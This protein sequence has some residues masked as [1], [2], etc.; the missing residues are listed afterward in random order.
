MNND[1]DTNE[2]SISADEINLRSEQ[3]SITAQKQFSNGA[4]A[5]AVIFGIAPMMYGIFA[6]DYETAVGGA[7]AMVLFAIAGVCRKYKFR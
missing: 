3:N 5:I 4:I 1:D 6:R 2:Y 7:F